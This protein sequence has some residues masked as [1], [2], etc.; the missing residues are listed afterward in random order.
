MYFRDTRKVRIANAS[1]ILLKVN[2]KAAELSIIATPA[3][4]NV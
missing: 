2:I 3:T 4:R 1:N